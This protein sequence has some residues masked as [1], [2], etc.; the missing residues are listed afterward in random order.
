MLRGGDE[1]V[2]KALRRRDAAPRVVRLEA[3]VADAAPDDAGSAMPTVP[4]VVAELPGG[5]R[6]S[7]PADCLRELLDALLGRG[8]SC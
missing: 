6:V 1:E 7:V 4:P 2:G 3:D 8:P 5:V